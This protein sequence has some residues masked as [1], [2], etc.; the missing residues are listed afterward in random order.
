MVPDGKLTSES[1]QAVIRG[2]YD[3][4][5]ETYGHAFDD[6]LVEAV[7]LRLIAHGAVASLRLPELA[8]GGRTDPADAHVG[9]RD[10]VFDDGQRLPTPRIARDKLLAEDTVRGPAIITQ[11]NSTTVVPPG[12]VARV[13]SHGDILIGREGAR[14]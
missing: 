3:V 1:A 7:T 13:L 12:Y 6:Q 4:H 8:H 10:T 11:H 14:A 2:F 9:T 5:K